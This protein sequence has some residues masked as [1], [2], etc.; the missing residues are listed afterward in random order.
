VIPFLIA[1]VVC[2]AILIIFP[3]IALFLP[4]LFGK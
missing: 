2:V 4:N 3:D 1:M